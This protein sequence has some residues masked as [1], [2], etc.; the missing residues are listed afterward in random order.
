MVVVAEG[1]PGTPVVCCPM[2][3]AAINKDRHAVAH[4]K[5]IAFENILFNNN[6]IFSLPNQF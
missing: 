3:G 6:M 4:P 5:R 1:E 2:T